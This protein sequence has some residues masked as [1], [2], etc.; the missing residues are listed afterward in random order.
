[1]DNNISLIEF[2]DIQKAILEAHGFDMHNFSLNAMKYNMGRIMEQLYIKQVPAFIESIRTQKMVFEKISANLYN[3]QVYMFRD[4]AFWRVLAEKFLPKASATEELKIWIPEVSKGEELYSLLIVL[5][6]TGLLNKSRIL[7][8]DICKTNLEQ[9]RRGVFPTPKMIESE[10]NFKRYNL[11]NNFMDYFDKSD[12]RVT[13]K[14]ELLSKVIFLPGFVLNVNLP[15]KPNFV[16]F[17]NKMIY[18]NHVL[19]Q[20]A[21]NK[22][23]SLMTGGGLLCLGIME[24]IEIF[25]INGKFRIEDQ[26]EKIYRRAY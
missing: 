22:V 24:D 17:R 2:R 6:E 9:C 11:K 15:F 1:M 7:A 16:L 14:H 8:T 10:S 25:E 23:H 20:Q 12:L 18:Y 21:I 5:K 19:E 13:L 3:E 4:P 26:E